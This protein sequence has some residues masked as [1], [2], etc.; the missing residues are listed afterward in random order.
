M[1]DKKESLV[2]KAR[3]LLRPY[4]SI[5]K[6]AGSPKAFGLLH[7]FSEQTVERADDREIG[8]AEGIPIGEARERAKWEAL[9]TAP[10][11]APAP[12]PVTEPTPVP[13]PV[14][15]APLPPATQEK[16]AVLE[17]R[18]TKRLEA[19]FEDRVLAEVNKRIEEN[20]LPYYKDQLETAEL[21]MKAGKPFTNKEY[22]SIL[23]AFH[24][25]TSTPETRTAVFRLMKDRE[26]LLRPEEKDK[27]L[28][29]RLP[30]TLPDLMAMRAAKLAK[31]RARAKGSRKNAS[32]TV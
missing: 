2:N 29:S 11:P 4:R 32:E 12:I 22:L 24:P 19:I 1:K 8:L 15:A 18:M 31:T 30:K 28:T 13:E 17:A 5:G 14:P 9:Q 25:D 3:L 23:M 27:P 7:G 6:T 21:V 10:E 26:V 16:L 20:V